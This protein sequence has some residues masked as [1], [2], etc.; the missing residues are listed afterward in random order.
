MGINNSI[1]VS[2]PRNKAGELLSGKMMVNLVR[3]DFHSS[4][5]YNFCATK[6][7]DEKGETTFTGLADGWY[8]VFANVD[9]QIIG[10]SVQ[11]SGDR[12]HTPKLYW[13]KVKID[14]GIRV[15]IVSGL[16]PVSVVCSGVDTTYFSSQIILQ[17][18]G[19]ADFIGLTD[20]KTY[21]IAVNEQYGGGTSKEI[22]LN[23]SD[24]S[25]NY[26]TDF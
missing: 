21:Q 22:T 12:E 8:H 14:I 18:G 16:P 10:T 13:N 5:Q 6:Y 4:L 7:T 24:I 2:D 17:I 19:K 1:I 15:T 26:P 9:G 11:I 20:T 25:L 23:G 3:A